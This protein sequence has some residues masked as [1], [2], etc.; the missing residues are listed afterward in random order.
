M[1]LQHAT[2]GAESYLRAGIGQELAKQS[3]AAL[4][5]LDSLPSA[6]SAIRSARKSRDR[7]SS[8]RPAVAAPSWRP[9]RTPSPPC[10]SKGHEPGQGQGRRLWPQRRAFW[11]RRRGG[12]VR[13]GPWEMAARATF[14]ARLRPGRRDLAAYFSGPD[15]AASRS[16]ASASPASRYR[17][18][19][20]NSLSVRSRA[21]IGIEGG[22]VGLAGQPPA[23]EVGIRRMGGR[24]CGGPR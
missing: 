6:A 22:C 21:G 7:Q 9:A 4:M 15:K 14:A 3:A 11:L 23:R 13:F 2:G 5:V 20:A 8:C 1:Q 24:A 18:R 12:R 10:G 16:A 17:R 19:R